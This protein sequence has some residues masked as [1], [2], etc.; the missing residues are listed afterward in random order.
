MSGYSIDFYAELEQSSSESARKLVPLILNK[1]SP[2]SVVDFGCGSGAFLCVFME[3]G[4]TEVLGLEGNWILETK[5]MHPSVPMQVHDLQTPINLKNKFDLAVCLEVA[6]HLPM[7]YAKV[8]VK[9]LVDASE[10]IIF[11]AAIPG[12][13]G[14]NHINLQFPEYW[15]GLFGEHDYF[16]E[17]DPRPEIWKLRNIAPWYKQN[18][19]VFR[20]KSI[21]SSAY[22]IP[23]RRFHPEI[24]LEQRTF[25]FK[26]ILLL[27]RITKKLLRMAR[28]R[29][30][31]G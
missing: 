6:E 22:V 1:F 29:I 28:V 24:A 30:R 3:L 14:T 26:L 11:S 8:L 23:E 20:K 5:P 21:S 12:Q 16:L 18:L 15:A 13:N 17:W 4:V 19:I 10:R 9:S 25:F 31:N 7:E 27:K 2:S